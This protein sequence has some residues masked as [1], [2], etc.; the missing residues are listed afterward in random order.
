MGILDLL[1]D[2][3]KLPSSSSE[4]FTSKIHNTWKSNTALIEMPSR[5]NPNDRFL[6]KHFVTDVCYDTVSG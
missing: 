2:E 5:P 1:D 4:N 6:I 3:S